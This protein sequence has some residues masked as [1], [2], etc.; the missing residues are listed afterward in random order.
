MSM[1]T[2]SKKKTYLAKERNST[3]HIGYVIIL[4]IAIF[5]LIIYLVH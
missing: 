1:F 2:G 4:A 5:V 3:V